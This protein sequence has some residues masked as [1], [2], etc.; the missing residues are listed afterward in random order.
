MENSTQ[1][2]SRSWG[3]AS[4]MVGP[5]KAH[6]V[7]WARL[8][9]LVTTISRALPVSPAVYLPPHTREEGLSRETA[10]MALP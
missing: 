3:H 10:D 7:P 6:Y 8:T 9:L 1:V 2:V 5:K 4:G